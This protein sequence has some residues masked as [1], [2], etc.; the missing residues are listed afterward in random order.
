MKPHPRYQY[1]PE[2]LFLTVFVY[3]DDWLQTLSEATPKAGVPRWGYG[4]FGSATGPEGELQRT[5]R[6]DKIGFV[7]ASGGL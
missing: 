7:G 6:T 3:I 2:D 5:S 1:K 4:L